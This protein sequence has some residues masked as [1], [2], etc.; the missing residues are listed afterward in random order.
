MLS[1]RTI[2]FYFKA[3]TSNLIA[4]LCSF[5]NETIN[6]KSLFK[7]NSVESYPKTDPFASLQQ[8]LDLSE[9]KSSCCLDVKIAI[10][11]WDIQAIY[12][13]TICKRSVWH[14]LPHY[15]R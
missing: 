14:C 9:Q 7:K 8:D 1:F 15:N 13:Y 5:V 10:L 2:P 11:E 6:E 12:F 4:W 3:V